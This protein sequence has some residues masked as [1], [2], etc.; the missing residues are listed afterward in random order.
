METTN[1][2]FQWSFSILMATALFAIAEAALQAGCSQKTSLERFRFSPRP[3]CWWSP[4][5]AQGH[6]WSL[7]TPCPRCPLGSQPGPLSVDNL[8]PKGNKGHLGWWK[9]S[10]PRQGWDWMSLKVLPSPSHPGFPGISWNPGIPGF[11]GRFLSTT[12]CPCQLPAHSP[13]QPPHIP[14]RVFIQPLFPRALCTL[15]TSLTVINAFHS[16]IP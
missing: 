8:L 7:G 1:A 10:L 4:T 2:I 5:G 3:G 6:P 16:L 13:L 9:V 11:P 14:Q 15:H 12:T